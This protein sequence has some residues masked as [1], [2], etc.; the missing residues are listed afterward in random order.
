MVETLSPSTQ[1]ALQEW[2]N[3]QSF[4]Y[5]RAAMLANINTEQSQIEVPTIAA[6]QENVPNNMI[7]SC[8]EI[9]AWT[10]KSLEESGLVD[11][12]EIYACADSETKEFHYVVVAEKDSE[13]FLIDLGYAQPILKVVPLNN[14]VI[15]ETGYDPYSS[16]LK[17]N[18]LQYQASPIDEKDRPC[19]TLN[20]TDQDG[21]P[22]KS[23]NFK[24]LDNDVDKSVITG[25][26]EVASGIYATLVHQLTQDGINE[27][28]WRKVSHSDLTT[29]LSDSPNAE[30]LTQLGK[31][32]SDLAALKEQGEI[33]VSF[34]N[35]LGLTIEEQNRFQALYGAFVGNIDGN[36]TLEHL[37]K[38]VNATPKASSE[39]H[40]QSFQKMRELAQKALSHYQ[41]N[42]HFSA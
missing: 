38:S 41:L 5:N 19:F 37:K 29:Q 33:K 1:Q 27:A 25:W 18:K 4:S 17:A 31:L 6:L 20:I 40:Q 26:I 9:A 12:A 39:S 22:L 14:T 2:V 28:Q 36:I 16:P 42:Q 23:F 34:T 10:A 21:K 13:Q 15:E 7:G 11:T 30:L 8:R 3:Q 32:Q 35:L 24:L